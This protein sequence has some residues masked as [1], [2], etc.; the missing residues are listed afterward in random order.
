MIGKTS[1]PLTVL[2]SLA[3][4]P[5]MS[6]ASDIEAVR[7]GFVMSGKD[8]NGNP[9]EY[10]YSQDRLLVRA[11]IGTVA[12]NY[13]YSSR[14]NLLAYA[15]T[16]NGVVYTVSRDRR[17]RISQIVG[18]NSMQMD[19]TY[20]GDSVVPSKIQIVKESGQTITP[21]DQPSVANSTYSIRSIDQSLFQIYD[22]YVFSNCMATTCPWEN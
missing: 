22:A 13:S 9:V 11:R 17:N 16:D 8:T 5:K 20:Q 18:A 14:D 3:A 21:Y 15:S 7:I 6:S 12:L 4:L 2:L 10:S 1:L 19:V